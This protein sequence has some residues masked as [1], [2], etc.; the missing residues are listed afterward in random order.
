VFGFLEWM[1][2]VLLKF[3]SCLKE[4]RVKTFS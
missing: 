1:I 3:P 4:K 2:E